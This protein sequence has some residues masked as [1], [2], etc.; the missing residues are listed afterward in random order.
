MDEEYFPDP[1]VFNP[2]RFSPD[3]R[4][5]IVKGSYFPFSMGPRICPGNHFAMQEA[6]IAIGLICAHV[7]F[8]YELEQPKIDCPVTLR[9]A[10]PL[11]AKVAKIE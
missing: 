2:E 4:E 11:F 5:N 9:F 7:D 6:A 8:E 1:F 10:D 3:N